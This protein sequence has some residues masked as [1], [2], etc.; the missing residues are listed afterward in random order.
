MYAFIIS[1]FVLGASRVNYIYWG[2]VMLNIHTY[3]PNLLFLHN[4]LLCLRYLMIK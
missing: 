2:S 1:E 4:T 3:L